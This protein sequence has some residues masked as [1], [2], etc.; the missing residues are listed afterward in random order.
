MKIRLSEPTECPL[1]QRCMEVKLECL[2]G[3]LDY[4]ECKYFEDKT[5]LVYITKT[6]I[7]EMY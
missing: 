4:E 6:K 1:A 7:M 3:S 5:H 2:E